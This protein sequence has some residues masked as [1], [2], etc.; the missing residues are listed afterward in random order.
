MNAP[1]V[2][3]RLQSCA[4]A[5]E[6]IVGSDARFALLVFTRDG[7]C[8]YVSNGRREDVWRAVAEWVMKTSEKPLGDN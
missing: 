6:G 4:K 1:E 5:I 2:R 8:E 7:R 3:A